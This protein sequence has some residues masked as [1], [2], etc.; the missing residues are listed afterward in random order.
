MPS[1]LPARLRRALHRVRTRSTGP[2]TSWTA[3]V[4]RR[5]LGASALVLALLAAL[6]GWAVWPDSQSFR[7]ED[8][9]LSVRSGPDG[10]E[11]VDLDTTLYLP[12]RAS[13]GQPVPAVLLAHGFGGTKESVRADAE[14]LA[15]HGYAVLAY[16]ARGFGRS[17]G[18]DPPGQSRLRGT[19]RLP[20]ARLARRPAG[21]PYRRRR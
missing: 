16:T 19:G 18:R 11:P 2:G 9:L 13:A 12:D 7:T 5:R 20:A 14:D 17:G 21:D 3:R 8:Q 1:A 10:T 4:G 15:E 6:V